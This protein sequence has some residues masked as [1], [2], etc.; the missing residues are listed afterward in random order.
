MKTFHVDNPREIGKKRLRISPKELNMVKDDLTEKVIANNTCI[1]CGNIVNEDLRKWFKQK[2]VNIG[3]KDDSGKH[4]ECGTSG[5]KQAYAKCVPAS[6]ARGMSKKQKQSATRR[7]RAAQQKAGRG[8]R[9]KQGAGAQGKKPIKVKTK[10]ESTIIKLKDLLNEGIFKNEDADKYLKELTNLLGEPTYKSDKEHGWYNVTLP[11]TYGKYK[12][13]TTKVDKVYIVDES[14]KHSFPADHRDYV[15]TIYSVPEWQQDKGKH[16]IDTEL[17]KQFAGVTGSIIIDG[18][19]GTV[20][21]RCGDL[22]ANDITINFVLDVVRGKAKPEKE[23]YAK[24][25]LGDK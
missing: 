3:K 1:H 4:P 25:I 10:T 17:F 19:K 23:E 9:G 21:A 7:K 6:K 11:E 20:T 8:G 22:V 14:V 2:W 16:I 18:L 13:L 15:Y 24:R 12:M 5:E